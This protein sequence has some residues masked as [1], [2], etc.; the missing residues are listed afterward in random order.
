MMI[1]VSQADSLLAQYGFRTKNECVVLADGINRVL[2]EDIFADRHHPAVDV[3]AMDGIAIAFDGYLSGV[4]QFTGRGIQK[5]GTAALFLPDRSS[6]FEIMT[7]ACLPMGCDCVIPYEDLK[8]HDNFFEYQAAAIKLN[9]RQFIRKAGSAFKAHDLLLRK[10]CQLN[11]AQIGIL[12]AVGKTTV[13]VAAI[14]RIAIVGTGDEVVTVNTALESFQ[15]RESNVY[16]L[17]AVL[18]QNGFTDIS[19][20]HLPDDPSR[21]REKFTS[22]FALFDIVIII[23]GMSK[24]KFD[25]VPAV[26]QDL[27]I[28]TIFHRVHQR[29]G[30]P[31][32]FA[33]ISDQKFI[34]GL[35]GNPVS[36]F[37]C[38]YR[39]VLPYLF[40]ILGREGKGAERAVL[41]NEINN[42]TEFTQFIP[43]KLS[44][45]TGAVMAEPV[46]MVDSGDYL[47]LTRSQGF[48]EV[49]SQG[50]VKKGDIVQL[51]SF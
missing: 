47:A 5:A 50:I 32:L 25:F 3:S 41:N 48:V 20:L 44:L 12:A 45:N 30:K 34:F 26:L 1:T 8:C 29:P 22:L 17:A 37:I 10:G 33:R 40:K 11:P 16:A 7:G 38:L 28:E 4:R 24:G 35:P 6:C 46:N 23:G 21:L 2:R 49:P 18:K 43:V 51:Y 31:M 14:P 19:L 27:E 13:E 36:A 39:Y 9:K 42:L 15:L